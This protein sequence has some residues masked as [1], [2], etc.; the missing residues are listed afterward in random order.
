[1]KKNT[2]EIFRF[3]ITGC[4]T[5]A[6]DFFIMSM[7]IYLTSRSLFNGFIDV[8]IHGKQI[9]KTHIVIIATGL[10]FLVGLICSYILSCMYVFDNNKKA[11]TKKGFILFTLLS[12]VGL[13]IHLIGMYI[14]Y[15]LLKI[16]EWI[17][18]IILTFVVLGFNYITRK[19]I[20][21]KENNDD[22]I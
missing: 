10:G 9:A 18:K 17:I 19:K 5:T 15:D 8:F 20:I 22:K 7:F 12:L 16:N 11:K 14:G 13:F 1:M 4:I 2:K 3:L 21:F 6:I